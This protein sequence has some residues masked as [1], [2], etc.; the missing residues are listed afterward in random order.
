MKEGYKEGVW[1]EGIDKK[2]ILKGQQEPKE[3]NARRRKVKKKRQKE[4]KR[5][6]EAEGRV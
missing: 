2:G 6:G 5:K 1:E 3:A 4:L